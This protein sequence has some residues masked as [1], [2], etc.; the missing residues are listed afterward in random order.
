MTLMHI[1]TLE[2]TPQQVK[3]QLELNLH[4]KSHF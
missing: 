2:V 4:Y 3:Y 1:C